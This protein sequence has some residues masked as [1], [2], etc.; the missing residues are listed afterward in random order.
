MGCKGAGNR[1]LEIETILPFSA[2]IP[3]ESNERVHSFPSPVFPTSVG[4]IHINKIKI[5]MYNCFAFL[6]FYVFLSYFIYYI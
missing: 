6:S 1:G 4:S 2:T 3:T 5:N